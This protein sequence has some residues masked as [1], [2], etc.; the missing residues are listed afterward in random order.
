MSAWKARK[1][2]RADMMSE[3][4][5][6]PAKTSMLHFL[7]FLDL[8]FRIKWYVEIFP[9]SSISSYIQGV[10]RVLCMK[11]PVVAAGTG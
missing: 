10:L 6:W 9:L 7:N 8:E 2:G 11:K 4:W 3:Y 5:F 1:L